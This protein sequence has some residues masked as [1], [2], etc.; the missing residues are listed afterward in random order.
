MP[1]PDSARYA[2]DA[3]EAIGAQFEDLDDGAGYLYRISKDGRFILGGGGNVCAYPVNSAPAYTISRDKA[4]SKAVL[5]SNGLPTIRGGL[6]FAH[7]RRAAMRGPGR[8]VADARIFAAQLG[9]PVFCKP[10]SGSRG[11]FAEIVP[12]DRALSDY[13]D[14]L[15][16][17]FEAFLV[18][19]VLHGVE[20][21]V[22]VQ[23][24]H[25]LFRSTKA[26][27][28]LKGDGVSTLSA[29]L[30]AMNERIGREG[31]SPTPLGALGLDPTLIPAK[32]TRILLPGRRNLSAAGEIEQVCEV[33]P[34][35]LGRLAVAAVGA[36]GLRAGAVDM[37]DVSAEEDLRELIIIEVNGNPGLRTLENAGR[38]DL[39]RTIWTTMLNA[40]LS[41]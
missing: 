24:A 4:H 14:R 9:Y 29:L 16:P 11:T 20:H 18:E 2:K 41:S 38:S 28:A 19:P 39:I 36:I 13:I 25:A 37:F 5:R 27:P 34:N 35:A 7:T 21:R 33:V 31:I 30:A 3:A 1:I 40:C 15:A 32:D 10:N 23:D 6:F 12:D 22:F 17:E 26:A 8:E